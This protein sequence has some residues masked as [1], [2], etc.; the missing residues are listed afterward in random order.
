[1]TVRG[2]FESRGAAAQIEALDAGAGGFVPSGAVCALFSG[3]THEL[4]AGNGAF[5]AVVGADPHA[6]PVLTGVLDEVLATGRAVCRAMVS[7]SPDPGRTTGEGLFDLIAEPRYD[8][9]DGGS[10]SGVLLSGVEVTAGRRAHRLAAE[11][12]ALLE[13]IAQQAPLEQVLDGMARVIEALTPREVLVSVLL[14]EPDGRHLRHGAAP[15]LP[16]FYCEAID[17]IEVGEGVGSCGTAA[18]RRRPVVA[19]DIATEPSWDAFRHLADAAG[20]AACWSTPIL[21]PDGALLGT[22]AMY[23]TAPRVPEEADLALARLFADTAALAIERHHTERARAAAE[24]REQAA[25]ADLAF[26]LKAG[27]SLTANLDYT[28]TL[29]RLA[30]CCVPE[31]APMCT[32]DVLEEGRVRRV[33]A[34][35]ASPAVQRALAGAATIE[36]IKTVLADGR[37]ILAR[38]APVGFDERLEVTGFH[39]VPLAA[40]SKPFGALTL[41]YTDE[42]GFTDESVALAEELARR[43]APA[44]YNARQHTERLAVARDLQS[45]LLLPEVPVLPGAEASVYYRAAGD[46]LEVGGDFYDLFPLPDRRWAFMLG[47]VCGRGALAATTTAL[48]RHTARAVAPLLPGPKEVLGAVN[49]ALLNRPDGHDDGFVTLVYGHFT[50]VPSGGIEIVMV[51][52]GHTLPLAIDPARS[53]RA[54]ESP[55]AALGFAAEPHLVEVRLRLEPGHSLLLYTDGFTER[56][57]PGG[58]CSA[59]AGWPRRWPS[60]RP[61]P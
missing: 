57:T 19:G 37:G 48:V 35:A 16:A 47:D 12:R 5:L 22:F 33:V 17:G 32:V 42:Q 53:V 15:S 10:I 59:S 50:P 8:A 27:T 20:L 41:L 60:R 3:S 39:T 23:H 6:V 31:L 49:R 18:H 52:A 58:N 56:A 29:E 11:Q 44:A 61:R 4:V 13:Q 43:A 1:M 40:G 21:G 7:L 51:R 55:G 9:D 36:S 2:D 25:R 38:R 34:A 28:Q 14:A 26:L 46:G 30:A 24:A 54:I 45:G